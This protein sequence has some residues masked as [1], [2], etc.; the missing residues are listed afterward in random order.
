MNKK[1][2]IILL[3]LVFTYNANSQIRIPNSIILQ[4]GQEIN[5]ISFTTEDIPEFNSKTIFDH[6]VEKFVTSIIKYEKQ[7]FSAD[8]FIKYI[9]KE[10]FPGRVCLSEAGIVKLIT[11]TKHLGINY[12]LDIDEEGNKLTIGEITNNKIKFIIKLRKLTKNIIQTNREISQYHNSARAND[13]SVIR[14]IE[15]LESKLSPLQEKRLEIIMQ[16]NSIDKE[17]ENIETSILEEK[18]SD[19][20]RRDKFAQK[21]EQLETRFTKAQ[22]LHNQEKHN[23]SLRERELMNAE[24]EEQSG[25]VKRI[26]IKLFG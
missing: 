20:Q 5:E 11:V 6:S 1:L 22:R 2:S 21:A 19:N 4:N 24:I 13:E 18:N 26:L 14:K 3:G 12:Y 10:F 7:I 17:I 16:L 15:N 8:N 23:K 25:F 9:I